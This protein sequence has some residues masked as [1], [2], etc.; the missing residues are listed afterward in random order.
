MFGPKSRMWPT[1]RRH[2]RT[3]VEQLGLDRF[4]FPTYANALGRAAIGAAIEL[5][6][7]GKWAI[8]HLVASDDDGARDVAFGASGR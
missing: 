3:R 8:E 1:S 2:R 6:Q 4:S 7:T 5:D